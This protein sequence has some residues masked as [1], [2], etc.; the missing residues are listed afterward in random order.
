MD[1]VKIYIDG[2]LTESGHNA[3][4]ANVIDI[5]L[6]A[7]T[8]GAGKNPTAFMR[9]FNGTTVIG[10]KAKIGVTPYTSNL[11]TLNYKILDTEFVG[12]TITR[13][14]LV[15]SLGVECA[16]YTLTVP[17]VKSVFFNVVVNWTMYA[18]GHP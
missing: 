6:W 9:A 1:N 14:A 7:L 12:A 15:D 17:I 8:G 11:V 16:S 3:Y 5:A 13:I 18:Y 10:D 4:D 2:E